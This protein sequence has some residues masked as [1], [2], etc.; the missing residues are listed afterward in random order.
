MNGRDSKTQAN[1]FDYSKTSKNYHGGWNDY[2]SF[3][4]TSYIDIPRIIIIQSIIEKLSVM[5]LVNRVLNDEVIRTYGKL[6]IL[7]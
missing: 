2:R 5:H 4:A 3:A 6:T 1:E 7:T